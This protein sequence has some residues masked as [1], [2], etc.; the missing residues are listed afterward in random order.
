MTCTQ[1][2]GFF[3]LGVGVGVGVG[4]LVGVGVGVGVAVGV[5]LGVELVSGDGLT[6]GDG[7]WVGAGAVLAAADGLDV[8]SADAEGADEAKGLDVAEGLDA[9]GDEPCVKSAAVRVTALCCAARVNAPAVVAGRVA[10]VPVGLR[11]ATP[12][13]RGTAWWEEPLPSMISPAR[14][15]KTVMP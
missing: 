7:L 12:Y 2:T 13:T 9:D 4:V 3:G 5:G 6:V 14:M 11:R 15:P 10:Q 8:G 1:S